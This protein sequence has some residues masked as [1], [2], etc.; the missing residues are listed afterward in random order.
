MTDKEKNDIY[1]WMTENDLEI[2]EGGNFEDPM[3]YHGWHPEDLA[4]LLYDYHEW[5]Q[6]K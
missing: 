4:Q 1:D 2:I 5:K 3:N 6:K